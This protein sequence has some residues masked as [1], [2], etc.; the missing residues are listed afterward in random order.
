MHRIS[1]FHAAYSVAPFTHFNFKLVRKVIN[2]VNFTLSLTLSL[3]WL[4]RLLKFSI[5]N[6]YQGNLEGKVFGFYNSGLKST[7]YLS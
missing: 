1:K 6:V 7:E 2:E 3:T 5:L 4:K